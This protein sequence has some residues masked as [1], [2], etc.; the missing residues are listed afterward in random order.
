VKIAA[1][2]PLYNGAP[3]IAGSDGTNAARQ[4]RASQL[5]GVCG[6]WLS[7]LSGSGRVQRQWVKTSCD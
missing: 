1:V 3:F 6:P 7:L 5:D 4:V 2:I